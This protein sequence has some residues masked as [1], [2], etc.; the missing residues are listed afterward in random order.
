[1]DVLPS[2]PVE[3][4]QTPTEDPADEKESRLIGHAMLGIG[5]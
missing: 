5:C 2:P 3:E 1:M 4:D